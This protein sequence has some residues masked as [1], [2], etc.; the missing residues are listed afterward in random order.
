MTPHTAPLLFVATEG[1]LARYLGEAR[2]FPMF[3]PRHEYRLTRRWRED[4]DGA[5]CNDAPHVG[6]DES[7]V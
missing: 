2:T 6:A 5:P 1:G 3:E 4:A 7:A